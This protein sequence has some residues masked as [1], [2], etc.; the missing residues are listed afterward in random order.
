MYQYLLTE[1]E[2]A[3][4]VCNS[5]SRFRLKHPA[6]ETNSINYNSLFSNLNPFPYFLLVWKEIDSCKKRTS[7]F[8]SKR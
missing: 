6:T 4:L 7:E 1:M 5:I 2:L 8:V 3:K